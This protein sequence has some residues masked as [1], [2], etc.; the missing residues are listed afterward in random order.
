AAARHPP[1]RS[2]RRARPVGAVPEAPR[3]RRRLRV[4]GARAR[5]EPLPQRRGHPPGRRHSHA[6]QMSDVRP[7][8][9]TS[10]AID[11]LYL[12]EMKEVRDERGAVREFY[13]ESTFVEAG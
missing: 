10:T 1:R 5:P 9:A 8:S 3:H 11:G 12:I 4:T 6:A 13:R 7:F 2:A